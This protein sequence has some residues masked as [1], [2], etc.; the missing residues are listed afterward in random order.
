MENLELLKKAINV[1]I[2]N[3]Y[4]NIRGKKH[5]FAEFMMSYIRKYIKTSHSPERWKS[6]LECFNLYSNSSYIE[7]KKY[8]EIFI[9]VLKQELSFNKEKAEKLK[10]PFSDV[11]YIKGVGPKIASMLHKLGIFTASDLMFYFPRKHIDYSMRTKIRD[12]EEGQTTTI[13]GHIKNVESFVTQK[14]L[15]IVKVRIADETGSI[16]INFF[17][18]KSTNYSL[19]RTKRLYPKG[20]GIIISG[21]VKI[22]SYDG[23]YTLDNTTYSIMPEDFLGNSKNL[24][25][26]RIVPIYSLSENLN[27]KT[28][29]NAIYNAIEMYKDSI[30]NVVPDYLRE[31]FNLLEKKDAVQQIHFPDS[32]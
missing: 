27:I 32:M 31:K 8:V 16:V 15:G 10:N 25:L 13:F 7:R 26:A 30:V 14:G 23:R 11:T 6:V 12:L 18:A 17:N 19:Q 22:N 2:D 20:A 5:Y 1:E 24:N 4:I 9:K 28:M 29:R 3:K 21:T